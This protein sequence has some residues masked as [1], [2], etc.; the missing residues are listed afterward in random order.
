VYSEVVLT[1]TRVF[2]RRYAGLRTKSVDVGRIFGGWNYAGCQNNKLHV[3]GAEV[4]YSL[5]KVQSIGEAKSQGVLL[6][7]RGR[8]DCSSE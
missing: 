4:V 5:W 8:S 6:I 1:I 2:E 7:G 3:M